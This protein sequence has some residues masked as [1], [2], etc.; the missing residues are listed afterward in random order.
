M[1]KIKQF[2][3]IFLKEIN[4]INN[5]I[6]VD[7]RLRRIITYTIRYSNAVNKRQKRQELK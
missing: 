2:A 6:Y 4:K 1:Q 7:S 5:S 3:V